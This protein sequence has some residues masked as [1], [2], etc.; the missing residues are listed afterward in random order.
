MGSLNISSIWFGAIIGRKVGKGK[1]PLL[2]KLSSRFPFGVFILAMGL[3]TLLGMGTTLADDRVRLK[4][5]LVVDFGDRV[6][7]VNVDNSQMIETIQ[8]PKQPRFAGL[9]VPRWV[10]GA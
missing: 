1:R 8:I 5:F 7:H 9:P 3:F 2:G 10:N 4:G 6:H